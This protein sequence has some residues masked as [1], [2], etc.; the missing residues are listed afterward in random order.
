MFEMGDKVQFIVRRD[1]EK[2]YIIVGKTLDGRYILQEEG[3]PFTQ[4]GFENR[5]EAVDA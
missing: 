4:F 5:I 3:S 2:P 1:T